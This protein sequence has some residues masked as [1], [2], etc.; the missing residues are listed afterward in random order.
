MPLKITLEK[1]D[2]VLVGD[3]CVIEVVWPNKGKCEL[4]FTA[5]RDVEIKTIYHDASKQ[6]RARDKRNNG[7]E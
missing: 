6:F 2:K 7:S 5:P 3:D 4:V 1:N